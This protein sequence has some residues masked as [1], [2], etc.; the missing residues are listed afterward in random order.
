MNMT[1]VS[2]KN[3]FVYLTVSLVILLLV[4][5]LVYQFPVPLGQQLVQTLTVLTL[6]SGVIG[7]RDSRLHLRTKLSDYGLREQYTYFGCLPESFG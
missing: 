1:C 4:A 6:A 3:N 2:E 7:L 5:A